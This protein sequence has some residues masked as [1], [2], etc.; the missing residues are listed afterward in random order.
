S[1]RYDQLCSWSPRSFC[2]AAFNKQQVQ[3]DEDKG[4]NKERYGQRCTKVEVEQRGVVVED[5]HRSHSDASATHDR[6]DNIGT[7]GKCEDNQRNID[8]YLQTQRQGDVE[9]CRQ[10]TADVIE[11]CLHQ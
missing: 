10:A 3:R 5:W 6:R 11:R 9:E 7:D 8:H 4:Y 2:A 1:V